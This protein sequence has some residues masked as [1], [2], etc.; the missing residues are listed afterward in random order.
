MAKIR[1]F[2]KAVVMEP[3][4]PGP[5][6]TPAQRTEDGA[7]AT[8]ELSDRYRISSHWKMGRF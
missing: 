5:R 2:R 6:E 7:G 3:E 1:A 4:A 8:W